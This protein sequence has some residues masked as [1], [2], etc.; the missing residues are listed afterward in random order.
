MFFP[1]LANMPLVTK[2][3][4]G[5]LNM[6]AS[7]LPKQIY[8]NASLGQNVLVKATKNVTRLALKLV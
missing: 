6:F 7:N 3:F 1:K 8:K 5:V 2:K 4:G